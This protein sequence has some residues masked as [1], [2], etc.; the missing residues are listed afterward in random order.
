VPPNTKRLVFRSQGGN[1]NC[2]LLVRRGGLASPQHHQRAQWGGGTHKTVT[3]HNPPPGVYYAVLHA[4]PKFQN[5]SV[6]A[7][8]VPH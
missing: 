8:V 6:V 5:V 1:G 3:W 2:A 7:H 4:Q